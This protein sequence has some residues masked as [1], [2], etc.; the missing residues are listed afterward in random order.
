M[1]DLIQKN[2]RI[3]YSG[4]LKMQESNS[5]NHVRKIIER[6]ESDYGFDDFTPMTEIYNYFEQ[7]EN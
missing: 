3:V 7:V 2:I 1:L 5:T 4:T 6:C